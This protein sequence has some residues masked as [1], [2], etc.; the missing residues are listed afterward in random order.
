MAE[1]ID[2][3]L[4]QSK[5]IWLAYIRRNIPAFYRYAKK[6]LKVIGDVFHDIDGIEDLETSDPSPLELPVPDMYYTG[7]FDESD[8]V[9]Q[10][11]NADIERSSS[12]LA[13]SVSGISGVSE[14]NSTDLLYFCYSV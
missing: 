12:G 4:Q 3:V 2:A 10:M 11:H 1:L 5:N 6:I 13:M 14:I 8:D 7:Y 9:D